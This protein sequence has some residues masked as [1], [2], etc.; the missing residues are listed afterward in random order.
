MGGRTQGVGSAVG[1]GSA[2]G[3]GLTAGVRMEESGVK[4]SGCPE[5]PSCPGGPEVVGFLGVG[6]GVSSVLFLFRC[7]FLAHSS[8]MCISAH[9]TASSPR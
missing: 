3:V 5:G 7:L 4:G 1:V 8:K 9:Q 2:A 6:L